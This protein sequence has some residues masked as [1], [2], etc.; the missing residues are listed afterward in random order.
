VLETA[1]QPSSERVRVIVPDIARRVVDLKGY[2]VRRHGIALRVE[3]PATFPAVI[4]VP[5]QLEQVLLNLVSNAHEALRGTRRG[6]IVIAGVVDRGQA[7][8]EV[9]DNGP[10]IPDEVLPRIFEPFYTTKP[11][12]T[13]LGLAISAGIV[14]DSGGELTAAN[15]PEGGAVFRLTLPVAP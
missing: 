9:R 4:A 5:F 12:G 1:R 8:I 10:G 6:T 3:F 15:R 13:G 2:D 11:D 14:R 7:V